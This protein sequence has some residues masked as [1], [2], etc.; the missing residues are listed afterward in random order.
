[1]SGKIL[2]SPSRGEPPHDMISSA[3]KSVLIVDDDNLIRMMFERFLSDHYEV[4]L[5][6]HGARAVEE[7]ERDR[8]DLMILDLRMPVMDGWQVLEWLDGSG[9]LLPVII[10]SAEM[11]GPAITSTL[12]RNRLTKP[13]TLRALREA[14]E[15]VLGAPPGPDGNG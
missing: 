1:L 11:R 8:P 4:R 10:L 6:A 9:H 3:R 5:A 7:I 15:A 13:V 12:V 2:V 14:C